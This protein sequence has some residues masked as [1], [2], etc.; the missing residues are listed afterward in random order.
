MSAYFTNSL[1]P[2]A[3][4]GLLT[5]APG[6]SFPVG[7]RVA[8]SLPERWPAVPPGAD[9]VVFTAQ[10]HQLAHT[11]RGSLVAAPF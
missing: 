9:V 6:G 11:G 2:P 7:R 1:T 4:L 5:S 10:G 8:R 3:G